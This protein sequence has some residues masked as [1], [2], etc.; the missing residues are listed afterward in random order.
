MAY[1][2]NMTGQGHYHFN[3]EW[4]CGFSESSLYKQIA[5]QI[6]NS[7]DFAKQPQRFHEGFQQESNCFSQV[8]KA[9]VTEL[10]SKTSIPLLVGGQ[11][12]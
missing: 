10:L 2:G 11:T 3:I 12:R 7:H 8:G 5:I 9:C 6:R 4:E 1:C